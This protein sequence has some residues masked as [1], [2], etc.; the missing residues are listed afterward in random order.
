MANEIYIADKVTLDLVKIDTNALK[1]AL[2]IVNA[3]TDDLQAS[4]SILKT[5]TNALKLAMLGGTYGSFNATTTILPVNATPLTALNGKYELLGLSAGNGAETYTIKID[6]SA[7][8]FVFYN[9][10]GLINLV[11]IGIKC[12][13]SM[14]IYHTSTVAASSA[15][16]KM[17][18]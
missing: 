6:G 4:A 7:N 5:D 8:M 12:N 18:L 2:A 17:V 3:D 9:S 16:F 15:L 14:I 13:S 11:G 1:T 10:T